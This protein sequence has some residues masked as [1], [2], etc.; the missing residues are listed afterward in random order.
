ML[1][2]DRDRRIET[3]FFVA[4]WQNFRASYRIG[5]RPS[6][7][8][9]TGSFT[10][11]LLAVAGSVLLTGVIAVLIGHDSAAEHGY[12][13]RGG[14]QPAGGKSANKAVGRAA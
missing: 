13:R 10:W 12:C 4:R 5:R 11:G 14:R 1:P 6:A 3:A 8:D 9:A 2:L 7:E